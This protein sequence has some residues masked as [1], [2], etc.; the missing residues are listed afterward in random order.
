VKRSSL[1]DGIRHTSSMTTVYV[2]T[3]GVSLSRT[4]SV[5]VLV[6][7]RINN[8][9]VQ[10]RSESVGQDKEVE[11]R[12]CLD[13]DRIQE[14]VEPRRSSRSYALPKRLR[15]RA[16]RRS[17]GPAIARIAGVSASRPADAD[18]AGEGPTPSE[19]GGRAHRAGDR[20]ATVCASAAVRRTLSVARLVPATVVCGER[21]GG[22]GSRST[23]ASASREYARE[24]GA[25]KGRPARLT[26]PSSA[27]RDASAGSHSPDARSSNDQLANARPDVG[28]WTR[29]W[30]WASPGGR[31]SHLSGTP[32]DVLR[33]TARECDS[34]RTSGEQTGWQRAP[35]SA[36]LSYV[37]LTTSSWTT[38]RRLVGRSRTSCSGG[39]TPL[40][41]GHTTGR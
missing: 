6:W 12:G 20:R 39:A 41:S 29:G 9:K 23:A 38:T 1:L 33:F 13:G 26:Y 31:R 37:D 18:R 2:R 10:T 24:L 5:F 25:K 34:S 3:Y 35:A 32:R 4:V 11:L 36:D 21:D 8:S 30:R 15:S 17:H 16:I 14:K 7:Q 22:S 40:W 19:T 27:S 28:R